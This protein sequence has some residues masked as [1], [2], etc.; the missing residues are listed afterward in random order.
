MAT[1]LAACGVDRTDPIN[2]SVGLIERYADFFDTPEQLSGIV[3]RFK[4]AYGVTAL[5]V[6]E[7]RDPKWTNRV[8]WID[9]AKVQL[10]ARR[11]H[12]QMMQNGVAAIRDRVDSEGDG[13]EYRLYSE[14]TSVKS[15]QQPEL[16]RD[17]LRELLER[18]RSR[19][20][21][22]NIARQVTDRVLRSGI[23]DQI[24]E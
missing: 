5:D 13:S 12:T 18:A 16:S 3:E 11:I 14:M 24:D 7:V 6:M 22:S 23:F 1:Y 15:E 4:Q 20:A 9:S 17:E 2:E 8:R 21:H 10:S 19:G